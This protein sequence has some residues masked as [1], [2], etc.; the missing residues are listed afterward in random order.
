MAQNFD[1]RRDVGG[2]RHLP[3]RVHG[4][5]RVAYVHGSNAHPCGADRSD[6]R[7]ATQVAAGDETGPSAAVSPESAA[8]AGDTVRVAGIVLKWLRTDKAANS[9]RAEEMIREAAGKGAKIVCTTECF[10]DGYAIKDKT[11][12]LDQ[13]RSVTDD[14]PLSSGDNNRGSV[15]AE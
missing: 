10:L 1:H 15:V 4:Q 14:P 5:H 7:A 2:G 3:A 9:R 8:A 11:I 6:R 12:P 13:Y